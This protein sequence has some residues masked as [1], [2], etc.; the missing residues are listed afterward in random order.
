MWKEKVVFCLLLSLVHGYNIDTKNPIIKNRTDLSNGI[1]GQSVALGEN[2]VFIGAPL[3]EDH[4]NV[5]SCPIE[6]DC[7]KIYG[8]IFHSKLLIF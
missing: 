1:F 3:D 5:Y 7:G 4:G 6:G 8:N 2:K